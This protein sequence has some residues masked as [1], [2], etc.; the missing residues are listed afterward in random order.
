M[1]MITTNNTEVLITNIGEGIPDGLPRLTCHTDLTECCRAGDHAGSEGLGRWYYPNGTMVQNS[2]KSIVAGGDFYIMRNAPQLIWLNR[3]DSANPLSPTGSYCCEIPTLGG[4]RTLCA[5][6]GK[7]KWQLHMKL[8]LT[9]FKIVVVCLSLPP[10]TNGMISYF[11]PTLGVGSVATHSCDPGLY[12][13]GGSNTR[14]CQSNGI[15]SGSIPTCGGEQVSNL[16]ILPCLHRCS[17]Q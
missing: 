3:R 2:T 12:M 7:N 11:D 15:W 4:E 13:V 6:I 9:V 5:K 1:P 10:L 16:V 17:D 8:F 14:T